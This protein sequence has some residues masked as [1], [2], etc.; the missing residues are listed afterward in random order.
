MQQHSDAGEWLAGAAQIETLQT[1]IVQR[2]VVQIQI[3]T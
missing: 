3:Y 1:A 2:D